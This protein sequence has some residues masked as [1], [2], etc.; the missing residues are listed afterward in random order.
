VR[1]IFM[2]HYIRGVRWLATR[3]LLSQERIFPWSCISI[4]HRY[5]TRL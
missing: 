1:F 5:F 4:C 2:F 3:P